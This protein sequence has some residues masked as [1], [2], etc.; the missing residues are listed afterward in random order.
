M[1]SLKVAAGSDEQT[2]PG[3]QQLFAFE[4]DFVATLRCIP[5]AVRFKL[6]RAGI[7]L[8]LRQWSRFL[9]QD[10]QALLETQCASAGEVTSYRERVVRLVALRSG[11]PAKPLV[12][13]SAAL[14]G[15]A[16]DVPEGVFSFA[17]ASHVA[18]PTREDWRRLSDLQRFALIKL[19]RDSHDNE[20]FVPAMRE[21]GLVGDPPRS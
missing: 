3:D 17:R 7:K 1:S 11:E 13:P 14:G 18:P 2:H 4:S 6:D 9:R 10:R 21:F 15:L 16:G 5:M 12:E 8:S 20:N 19:T